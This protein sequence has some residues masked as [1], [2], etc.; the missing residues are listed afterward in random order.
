MLPEAR[1]S[2]RLPQVQKADREAFSKDLHEVFYALNEAATVFFAAKDRSG[3]LLSS[4][5]RR[6]EKDLDSLLTFFQF[7]ATYRTVLRTNQSD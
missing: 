3:R 4:A 6:V 7:D 5:G 1:Q 2:Q